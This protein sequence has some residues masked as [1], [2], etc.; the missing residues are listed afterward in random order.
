MIVVFQYNTLSE[1]WRKSANFDDRHTSRASTLVFRDI[2]FG[3]VGTAGCCAAPY[4]FLEAI[5]VIN[6]RGIKFTVEIKAFHTGRKWYNDID[7]A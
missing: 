2:L 6:A 7:K 5:P 1:N 4:G 3:P